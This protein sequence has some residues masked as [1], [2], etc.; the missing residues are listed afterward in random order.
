MAGSITELAAPVREDHETGPAPVP[1][2]VSPTVMPVTVLAE[3]KNACAAGH[4][5]VLAERHVNQRTAAVD[6]AIEIAPAPVH[7]EVGS[8]TYQ[9]QPAWPCRRRRRPSANAGVSL[10]FHSRTA[11]WLNTMPR[12]R[13]ISGRSRRLSL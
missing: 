12:I 3:R 5:A 10:A 4:V 11:S 8:S 9:L 7:L 2:F 6:C 13:T 1:G